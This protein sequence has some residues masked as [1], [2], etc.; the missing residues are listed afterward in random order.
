MPSQSHKKRR[1]VCVA[2][3][4]SSAEDAELARAIE[5]SR[6]SAAMHEQQRA[7]L[8]T[9]QPVSS[10]EA[11]QLAK[12]FE[13]SRFSASEEEDFACALHLSCLDD[14][15]AAPT[16][17]RLSASEE[18]DLACALHLSSLD[19]VGAAPAFPLLFSCMERCPPGSSG[20]RSA[21]LS[22][23]A[24][25]DHSVEY[26]LKVTMVGDTRRLSL[27][28]SSA[29]D[30]VEVVAAIHA[31]LVDGFSLADNFGRVLTYPDEDGDEC[32]LV[33][34]TVKD[35]LGLAKGRV[36]R[37]F[38]KS[39]G[40]PVCEVVG[41]SSPVDEWSRLSTAGL[42]GE[43]SEFSISTPRGQV[44]EA[45]SVALEISN[46]DDNEDWAL[47]GPGAADM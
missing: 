10:A 16:F 20:D 21:Q 28:W 1:A 33:E 41:G 22:D 11:A 8:P 47:V 37:L 25:S 23:F 27:A 6:A 44:P 18:E 43:P 42:V 12:A 4:A 30:Y 39:Q 45:V 26:V 40:S 2:S 46:D 35:F 31:A 14:V 5:L 17:P 32:T 36:L 3:R 15:G 34:S 9:F 38:I 29:A 7:Q 13:L 19:D 24:P